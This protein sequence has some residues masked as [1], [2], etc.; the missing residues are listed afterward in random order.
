[1]LKKNSLKMA[2]LAAGLLIPGV[3]A[4]ATSAIVT[5]DLN[6]RTGPDSSYPAFD[7]IPEGD[8]V[9]V[10]GC[11][12]GYGWCDIEWAGYRG[13]VSGDYLAYLGQ[14]YYRRPISSIGISIG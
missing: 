5:T 11:L 12:D 1:M 13:W 14:R 4:A 3:A 10:Y 2:A 9:T 6:F 8:D 7:V